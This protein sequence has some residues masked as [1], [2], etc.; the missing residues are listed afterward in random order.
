MAKTEDASVFT[1]LKLPIDH[2]LHMFKHQPCVKLLKTTKHD[3]NFLKV[4]NYFFFYDN[5]GN[6]ILHCW[7]LIRHFEDLVQYEYLN[8][9]VL[10]SEE[11]P[12][13]RQA[14]AETVD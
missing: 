7:A 4:G 2:I 11:D 9:F 3:T 14:L 13:V 10:N 5:R 1:T 6:A 8:E 12:E